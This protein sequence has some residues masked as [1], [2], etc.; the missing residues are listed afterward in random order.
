MTT[1][2]QVEVLTWYSI[3]VMDKVKQPTALSLSA[4]NH[5]NYQ[6]RM[7]SACCIPVSTHNS[8]EVATKCLGTRLQ[9]DNL[10]MQDHVI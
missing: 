7:A 5:E 9:Y 4:T 2:K 8:I 3:E 6:N 10:P 1:L